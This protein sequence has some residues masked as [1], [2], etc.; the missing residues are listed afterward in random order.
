MS[1]HFILSDKKYKRKWACFCLVA[2]SASIAA[3]KQQSQLDSVA[4]AW[5]ARQG[6]IATLRFR[7]SERRVMAKGSLNS[8]VT[9]APGENLPPTDL[10]TTTPDHWLLLDGVKV[11]YKAYTPSTK[12]ENDSRGP[13]RSNIAYNGSVSK[14]YSPPRTGPGIGTIFREAEFKEIENMNIRA[15]LLAY[16]ALHP[17]VLKMSLVQYTLQSK[18]AMVDGRP[19]WLLVEQSG[20]SLTRSL[21]LDPD[22]SFHVARYIEEVNE[23]GL[24]PR[25]WCKLDVTYAADARHA[26]VPAGWTVIF[27]RPNGAMSRSIEASVTQYDFNQ[28]IPTEE[29][30]LPFPVGTYVTDKR[31]GSAW[32]E[33]SGGA[34]RVITQEELKR[35]ASYDDLLATE[36]GSGGLPRAVVGWTWYLSGAALFVFLLVLWRRYMQHR[37][38]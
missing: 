18:N 30:E 38:T 5:N 32:I 31:D 22:R 17:G 15:I 12:T 10:V 16:R 35:G 13:W 1:T 25:L 26:W 28:S 2:F 7:W 36:S 6:E 14:M 11:S 21:W 37:R 34:R 9:L 8:T 19:H 23:P 33:R 20:G 27:L 29:F 24:A 3:A 4:K